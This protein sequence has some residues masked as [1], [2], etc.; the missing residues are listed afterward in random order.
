[1]LTHTVAPG[2]SFAT[3]NISVNRTVRQAGETSQASPAVTW[4]AL[5]W[6]RARN[7]LLPLP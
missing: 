6:A 4:A 2:G 3:Y 5:F 1:M 7:L